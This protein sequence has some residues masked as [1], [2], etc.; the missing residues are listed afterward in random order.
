MRPPP[1][2]DIVVMSGARVAEG[3]RLCSKTLVSVF[4]KRLYKG[5]EPFLRNKD[6]VAQK[7]FF[8]IE[9]PSAPCL[10]S[11][12]NRLSNPSSLPCP[13]PAEVDYDFG[14]GPNLSTVNNN[15]EE[16]DYVGAGQKSGVYW[17]RSTR[18]TAA[19]DGHI[20]RAGLIPGRHSM[21]LGR[22]RKQDL[23]RG[24]KRQSCDRKT[25]T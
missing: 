16:I 5:R 7:P 14:S 3:E 10:F 6:I 20:S 15:G 12:W 21:V 11:L 19:F 13:D 17:G 24:R 18:T 2:N 1:T 9:R 22:R 4:P 25:H 23:L 8:S